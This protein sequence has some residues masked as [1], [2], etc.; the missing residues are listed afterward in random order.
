MPEAFIAGRDV[1]RCKNARDVLRSRARHGVSHR[2]RSRVSTTRAAYTQAV[3]LRAAALG[4]S[5]D[6]RHDVVLGRVSE[7]DRDRHAVDLGM[8][9]IRPGKSCL[10]DSAIDRLP[11]LRIPRMGRSTAWDRVAT[12]PHALSRSGARQSVVRI[13]GGGARSVRRFAR[14]DDL[15][16]RSPAR[17]ECDG[18]ASSSIQSRETRVTA[19]ALQTT[20]NLRSSCASSSICVLSKDDERAQ[21]S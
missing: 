11:A 12:P 10:R 9:A 21:H 1:H 2:S 5:H 13:S 20:C 16:R 14:R 19:I 4:A 7:A 8:C 3:S 15:S 18:R 17:R 6:M